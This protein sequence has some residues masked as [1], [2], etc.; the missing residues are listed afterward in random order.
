[1]S[2][3][4]TADYGLHADGEDFIETTTT[5]KL[6]ELPQ[7]SET[8]PK[9]YSDEPITVGKK[10]YENVVILFHHLDGM[11]SYCTL[12]NK[13][14]DTILHTDG[15]KAVMHLQAAT[16]LIKHKDG[17]RIDWSK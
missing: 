4:D 1:M 16:P 14:G 11:Y 2:D 9:I 13:E 7:R 12:L 8:P 15:T 17:Y 10:K 5:T 6:Y 3:L